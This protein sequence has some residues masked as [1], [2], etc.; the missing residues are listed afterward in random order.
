[1][2]GYV[3]LMLL[4][5]CTAPCLADDAAVAAWVRTQAVPFESLDS[6]EY[7]SSLRDVVGD[8]SVVSFGEANHN[9]HEFLILR[10]RVF[11]YLV[12]EL[13]YTAFAA[14]TDFV[15]AIE[16]DRYVNAEIG[17]AEEHANAV[18]SWSYA[19]FAENRELIDWLREY[20]DRP[21]T[22]RKVRFYGLEAAGNLDQDARH[23]LTYALEYVRKVDSVAADGLGR[24]VNA[25]KHG[26]AQ[27]EYQKLSARLRNDM[28]ADIGDLVTA[29]EQWHVHWIQRSSPLEYHRAYRAA[30]AARQVA[31][32]LRIG[33]GGR[34]IASFDNLRWALEREGPAGRIFVFMHNMHVTRWRKFAPPDHP[35]HS[36][37]GEHADELLGKRMVVIGTSH[38]AGVTRNWLDL[39]GFDNCERR[40]EPARADSFDA[41]LARAE[42]PRFFLKLGDA[43][44][45]VAQWLD[46]ERPVR[47]VN[48]RP[49]YSPLRPVRSFDAVFF[50]RDIQPLRFIGG[51]LGACEPTR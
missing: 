40:L 33:G 34:D 39:E 16:V 49:G 23:T 21:S 48:I 29:F 5:A 36:S 13:G 8:A 17:R 42:M 7:F 10:N 4:W 47:N 32:S 50:V 18:L 35:L 12:E 27:P 9:A 28:V 38:F 20:N 43:P 19:S 30:I 51:R 6:N 41:E 37:L 15:R 22:K 14:E 11:R 3:L 25:W 44:A 31:A 2:R 1:M 24:R 45:P 26:F 46:Q